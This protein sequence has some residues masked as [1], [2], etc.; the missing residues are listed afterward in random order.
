MGGGGR[1]GKYGD[2]KRKERLR[3]GS[4][5]GMELYLERT[6]KRSAH[7][8]TRK[9]QFYMRDVLASDR[10]FIKVLSKE[11]FNQYGPYE[12]MIPEWLYSSFTMTFIACGEDK[13]LGFAMISRPLLADK[14]SA[15]SELLAIAVSRPVRGRGIGD[16]LLEEAERRAAEMGAEAIVLH[17][18][19]ENAIGQKLFLRHGFEPFMNKTNYY[20]N[21]QEA[22]MMIKYL[23][24]IV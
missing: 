19:V 18:A 9:N 17:S 16:L 22:I 20:P 8:Y 23:R 2:F 4:R 12:D 5:Q 7:Y 15:F 6:K 13:S 10:E 14:K 24:R 11:A 21:G 1:F 3:K